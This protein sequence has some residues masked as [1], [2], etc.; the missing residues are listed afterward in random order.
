MQIAFLLVWNTFLLLMNDLYLPPFCGAGSF[1][2]IIKEDI[3]V[4]KLDATIEYS[5]LFLWM[6]LFMKE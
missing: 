6:D 1:D 4:Y 2:F 3:N 5:H